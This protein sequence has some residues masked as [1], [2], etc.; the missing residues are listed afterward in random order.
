MYYSLWRTLDPP[1]PA[2]DE[3]LTKAEIL[4]INECDEHLAGWAA[5]H[6]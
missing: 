2:D 3:A 5:K 1:R 4:L 6:F